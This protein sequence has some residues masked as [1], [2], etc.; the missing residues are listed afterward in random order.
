[1][2]MCKS[3]S[4]M[5]IAYSEQTAPVGPTMLAHFVLPILIMKLEAYIFRV[6]YSVGS[7]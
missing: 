4:T 1:M 2:K 6:C 7:M 5:Q 3:E